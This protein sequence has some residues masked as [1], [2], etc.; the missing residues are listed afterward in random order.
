[1]DAKNILKQMSQSTFLKGTDIEGKE[2]T[3]TISKVELTEQERDGKKT[4]Q[5][6]LSFEGKEKRLGL[7]VGNT[8]RVIEIHGGETE[9]WLGRQITLYTEMVSNP[10]GQ[11]VPGIKV[12]KQQSAVSTPE[13]YDLE[14]PTSHDEEVDIDSIPF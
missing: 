3:V 12:M 10:Q 1:M 5:L 2:V 8:E 14:A 9:S 13:P 7:N 6:I 4:P 11:R